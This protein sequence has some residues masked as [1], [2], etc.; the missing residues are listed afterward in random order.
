MHDEMRW[1]IFRR[2]LD[3]DWLAPCAFFIVRYVLVPNG[4]SCFHVSS[5][6][7][8][9]WML[10]LTTLPIADDVQVHAN[11]FFLFTHYWM[12]DTKKKWIF[13]TFFSVITHIIT[14]H[15]RPIE[16]VTVRSFVRSVTLVWYTVCVN[17]MSWPLICAGNRIEYSA[18]MRGRSIGWNVLHL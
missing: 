7:G 4:I 1:K 13:S 17:M 6:N 14:Q 2:H 5:S 16:A 18:Q 9:N 10:Q 11:E 8:S 3:C 12:N 15:V